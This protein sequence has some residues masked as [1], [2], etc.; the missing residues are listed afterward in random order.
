MQRLIKSL[1]LLLWLISLSLSAAEPPT[2]PILRLENGMHTT[3]IRSIS[4]DAQQ[5]FVLTAS[6]DKTARLWSVKDG[7]LLRTFRPPQGAG[8]EGKLYAAA[9]SPDGNTVAVAGWTGY[10]WDKKVSIYLFQRQSGQLI[11]RL[12]DLPDVIYHL[13]FSKQGRYLAASINGKNGIRVF[14]TRTGA[15]VF[16]DS[17]YGGDSA[18]VDFAADGKLLSSSLDGY[19]RL[20]SADFKLLAK[21][22]ALGGQQPFLARF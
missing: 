8:D 10:E 17:D 4:T 20:Y 13:S 9:L 14:N 12:Q 22:T 15:L 1:P 2:A 18:S 16:K 3:A 7:Q 19:L 5:R 21:Q 11:Q 6:D